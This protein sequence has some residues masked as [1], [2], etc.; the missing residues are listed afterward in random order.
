MIEIEYIQPTL[1]EMIKTIERLSKKYNMDF[2]IEGKGNGSIMI[3][4]DCDFMEIQ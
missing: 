1:K 4:P 2:Y 3:K